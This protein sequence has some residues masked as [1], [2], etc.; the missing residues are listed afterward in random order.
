MGNK[1]SNRKKHFSEIDFYYTKCAKCKKSLA[2]YRAKHD[3]FLADI[4][5][6]FYAFVNNDFYYT[7]C[8]LCANEFVKEH[9]HFVK[10]GWLENKKYQLI[11]ETF[12]N[13]ENDNQNDLN[14]LIF[15]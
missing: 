8:E 3:E 9:F 5:K 4:K 15:G 13:W 14:F 6:Y 2:Y 10:N 1:F 7:S 12:K 11:Y